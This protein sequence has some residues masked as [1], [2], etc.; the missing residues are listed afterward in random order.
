MVER[1]KPWVFA[2]AYSVETKLRVFAVPQAGTGAPMYHGPGWTHLVEGVCELMPIELPGRSSRAG[3]DP[4]DDMRV[5]VRD[6]ADALMPFL[7]SVEADNENPPYVL[8]GHSMGATVC[9]ELACELWRRGAVLPVKLYVSGTRPP[10]LIAPE[11]DPDQLDPC[12]GTVCFDDFWPKFE[13]RY[14]RNPALVS[15][16]VREYLFETIQADFR[17]IEKYQPATKEMPQLPIP[18]AACCAHG[19][20]RVTPAQLSAWKDHTSKEFT[21]HWFDGKRNYWGNAH[22]YLLDAPAKF[23]QWLAEDILELLPMVDPTHQPPPPHPYPPQK[24]DSI[25]ICS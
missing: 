15:N 9:Y 12:L 16:S 19:D 20:N 18:I 23:Q 11:H 10:H 22:R 8:L 14:G 24:P 2:K 17:L 4:Y 3:E 1:Y 6:L 25:C 13:A 7:P 21:E 5:L